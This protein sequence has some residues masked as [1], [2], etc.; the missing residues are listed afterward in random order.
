MERGERQKN[1]ELL[2]IRGVKIGE[3][4]WKMSKTENM[5]CENIR[6]RDERKGFNKEV[7]SRRNDLQVFQICESMK[8]EVD[9]EGK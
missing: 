1:T 4:A 6:R 2:L 8:L 7:H 5:G 3:N 9:A